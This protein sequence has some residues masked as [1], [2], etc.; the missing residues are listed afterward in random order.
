MMY[1][2]LYLLA[3]VLANL[4]VTYFGPQFAIL[5]SFLLIGLDLTCRDRLHEQWHGDKLWIKMLALIA[6]GSILSAVLSI[7]AL[8]IAIAS[9][10]AF[11]A[12]GLTDTL[13]FQRLFDR[14]TWQRVNG[15]NL[16]S[17]AVDSVV[18]SALAFGFPLAWSIVIGQY[19]AKV[20]GGLFWSFLFYRRSAA[21]T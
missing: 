1:V 15:S 13:I 9:F 14:P 7:N 2:G 20:L 17:A 6:S 10:V 12:T 5:N 16:A 19:I 21:R 8:P 11:A 4:S 3:I 18:F